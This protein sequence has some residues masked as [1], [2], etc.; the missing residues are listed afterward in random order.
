MGEGHVSEKRC[1]NRGLGQSERNETS[2]DEGWRF[3]LPREGT[4]EHGG[5][6]RKREKW[7]E[8][9]AGGIGGT[10]ER[11]GRRGF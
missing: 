6:E 1:T 5:C 11:D 2:I 4:K 3:S 9:V 8:W 7:S 10:Q